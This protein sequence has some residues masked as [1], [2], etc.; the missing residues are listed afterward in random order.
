[1]RNRVITA[2]H[3]IEDMRGTED[4]AHLMALL[5]TGAGMALLGVAALVHGIIAI[6][7]DMLAGRI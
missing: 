6:A 4:Y 1:M 5:V 3:R 2:R 7:G